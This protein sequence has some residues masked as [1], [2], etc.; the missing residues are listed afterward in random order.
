[1]AKMTAQE[2]A[3][4]LKWRAEDDARIMAQYNEIMSDKARKNR[5]IKEAQSQ[6][7]E[8]QKRA[9][10]MKNVAGKKGKINGTKNKNV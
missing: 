4:E 10:I 8:L 6:A 2:K 5:A 1:M 7:N 9:N 3:R